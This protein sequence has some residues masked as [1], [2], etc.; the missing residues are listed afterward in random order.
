MRIGTLVET[1]ER[2]GMNSRLLGVIVNRS[3]NNDTCTVLWSMKN[4]IKTQE[5]LESALVNISDQWEKECIST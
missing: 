1:R 5:H 2:W 4:S 3:E